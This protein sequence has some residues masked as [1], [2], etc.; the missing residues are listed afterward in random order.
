MPV[1]NNH[2]LT[3]LTRADADADADITDNLRLRR[4]VAQQVNN[5]FNDAT[6]GDDTLSFSS[7]HEGLDFLCGVDTPVRAMYGGTVTVRTNDFYGHHVI[8]RSYTDRAN[9]AGFEHLYGHLNSV[10]AVLIGVNPKT[11]VDKGDQI[12]LSG[13]SGNATGYHLHV[14][15]KPFDESGAPNEEFAPD[16]DPNSQTQQ[17]PP[18]ATRIKGCMNFACFLPADGNLPAITADGLLLSARDSDARIPVFADKLK[19]YD[20]SLVYGTASPDVLHKISGRHI[21]CYA[22]TNRARIDGITWYE[23]QFTAA[24]TLWVPNRGTVEE[25]NYITNVVTECHEDKE[26]VRVENTKP[27]AD[28]AV[29]TNAVG[30]AVRTAPSE[31]EETGTRGAMIAGGRYAIVGTLWNPYY[32]VSESERRWWQMVFEGTKG[33]V[34]N[35]VVTEHGDLSRVPVA[36]PPAPANLQTD[37]RGATV[38]LT[39][40]A[41]A[42]PAG[43][44]EAIRILTGYRVERYEPPSAFSPGAATVF[45]EVSATTHTW[46]DTT[47]A[48]GPQALV[49]YRVAAQFA[50]TVGISTRYRSV[51]TGVTP[52]NPNPGLGTSAE[53]PV[54]PNMGTVYAATNPGGPTRVPGGELT[55]TSR[56]TAEAILLPSLDAAVADIAVEVHKTRSGSQALGQGRAQARSA[57]AQS[58][59]VVGWVPMSV[60]EGGSNWNPL[61]RALPQPPFVRVTAPGLVP[62]RPGPALGYTEYVAQIERSGGWYEIIGEN[63]GWWQVRV[64]AATVGWLRAQDVETTRPETLTVVPFV[65]ESPAPEPA[66]PGG[67]LPSGNAITRAAG[68]YLNLA[69]SWGGAWAVSKVGTEVTA[70]FQSTRSPVQWYARTNVRDLAVLPVDFRPRATQDVQVTGVHRTMEG[71][72]YA[73]APTATFTLRVYATGQVRYV[74]GPELDHVGYL[75]YEVG[76]ATSGVSFT[77]RTQEALVTPVVPG[78][79]QT[80]ASG[81]YLNQQENT[82][83]NWTLSRLG[84]QVWGS[85]SCGSSPVDYYANG[86]AR[87]AQLLLPE[88]YR[89]TVDKRFEVMGAVRVEKGAGLPRTCGG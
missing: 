3:V 46:T 38:R 35:D 86:A 66:G 28:P 88:A 31:E 43:T 64:D 80:T 2:G 29:S 48:T 54:W 78:P 79:G 85:F 33:W 82:G 76:T 14:H 74:D 62:V 44:P 18:L 60:L 83:S 59:E 17:F 47:V 75:R 71:V 41:P 89:P 68:H 87:E 72:D 27:V 57:A 12:G 30:T 69:N 5:C 6:T 53:V 24:E 21:G 22:V 4:P 37:P 7:G 11:T 63:Q 10:A 56:A 8:I 13:N 81:F 70:A 61:V 55:Q 77:W 20:S 45:S 84:T 39:W 73:G 58:D 26:W 52:T 23:I 51:T 1:A 16:N 50:R 42:W 34:R 49:Y 32:A 25:R 40:M 67:T 65:D 36:W 19:G 9:S 15:V